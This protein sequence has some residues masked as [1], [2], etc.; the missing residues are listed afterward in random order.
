MREREILKSEGEEPGAG[1]Q[2]RTSFQKGR[3][4]EVRIWVKTGSKRRG[5]APKGVPHGRTDRTEEGLYARSQKK[6]K[7]TSVFSAWIMGEQKQHVA[8]NNKIVSTT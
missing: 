7:V 2:V 3:R 5:G 1:N 8:G 6:V 4:M